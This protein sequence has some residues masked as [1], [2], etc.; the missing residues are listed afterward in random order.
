[1]TLGSGV[2]FVI[3]IS[4]EIQAEGETLRSEIGKLVNSVWNK[5]ELS[6]QRKESDIEL[7][8]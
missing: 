1:V 7:V 8:Y 4:E 5:E 3:K 6:D 2:E